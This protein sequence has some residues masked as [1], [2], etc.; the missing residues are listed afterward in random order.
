MMAAGMEISVL[1]GGAAE[2]GLDLV[3]A[4]FQKETGHAVRIAYNMGAEGPRR[5]DAGDVFDVVVGGSRSL[6]GRLAGRVEAGAV[7][8]G[9]VGLGVMVRPGAP[10]PDISSA[11]ALKRA[12]LEAECVLYTTGTSGVYI[13]RMLGKLGIF[14]QVEAKTTRFPHGP[15]LMDRVLAGTGREFA[16]LPVTFIQSRKAVKFVGP[17]PEEVQ[18][19]IEFMAVPTLQ[20]RNKE[21]AW[22][23]VRFCAGAGK[24]LLVANGIS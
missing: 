22:A 20:S 9:R 11:E 7:N 23:F 13:E 15:E 10:M 18:H 2:P 21:A 6:T 19:Y 1:S 14:E 4:A 3:A 16:F 5:M 24:P 12:L 17:L 8:I